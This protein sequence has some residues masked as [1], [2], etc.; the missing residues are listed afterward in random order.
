ME[1]GT[2]LA[3]ARLRV[4]IPAQRV[5]GA[6]KERDSDQVEPLN[7]ETLTLSLKRRTRSFSCVNLTRDYARFILR[8][9]SRP[10]RTLPTMTTVPGSGTGMSTFTRARSLPQ[11]CVQ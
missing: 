9:P 7:F 10:A 2:T 3:T 8:A 6:G 11:S 1:N 5:D 4:R